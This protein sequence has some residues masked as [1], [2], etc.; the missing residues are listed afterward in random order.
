LEEENRGMGLKLLKAVS[1]GSSDMVQGARM[2]KG[3][4]SWGRVRRGRGRNPQWGK[5]QY[6]LILGGKQAAM[7]E[8]EKGLA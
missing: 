5:E 6:G 4:D 3:L 8:N 7:L 2:K 1:E